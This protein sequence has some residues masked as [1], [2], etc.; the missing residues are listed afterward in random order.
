MKKIIRLFLLFVSIFA[1][2]FSCYAPITTQAATSPTKVTVKVAKKA[3]KKTITVYA[4]DKIE[5]TVKSGSKTIKANKITF[6][7]S[8]KKNAT[9]TKKGVIT[10]KKAGTVKITIAT[11]DKK[12]Y[13]CVITLKI[14]KKSEKPK[15]AA[16]S[17]TLD[18]TELTL[19][20]GETYK[21][22]PTILPEN[23][24]DK[25]L[26]WESGD[27]SVVTVSKD[28]TITAVGKG[29]T[30]VGVFNKKNNAYVSA[31]CDVKVNGK[32][33]KTGS[34][35]TNITYTLS[36]FETNATLS[37]SGTGL[38]T[39]YE[40]AQAPWYDYHSDI[41]TINIASGITSIGNCAFGFCSNLSNIIIPNTITRIGSYSF[42][43]CDMLTD[44]AIPS[45]VTVIGDSA[46]WDCTGLT[47]VTLPAS[48]TTL[49]GF[50][51]INCQN[52]KTA[53]VNCN[54]TE[55]PAS[56]F[57]SCVYLEKV[58]IPAVNKINVCA[59]NN[60]TSLKDVYY[61]GTQDQWNSVEISEENAALANATIHCK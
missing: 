56:M 44:I 2:S 41:T 34:A 57:S 49:E 47:T 55:I 22:I 18:K 23:T 59:F 3:K 21:L 42:Y 38:M 9:V 16:T 26:E 24:T 54:I 40:V 7:T 36:G 39:N 8:S 4:G 48:V 13:S 37:F 46:F 45:S 10:V 5:L 15:I 51:F 12:K 61:A 35:G 58:W 20:Q 17:I 1:L 30:S 43:D 31:Y 52:L 25:T 60:C 27:T 28:G 6:K 29:Q 19:N 33:S 14:K 50:T 32:I 53:Y 11:K